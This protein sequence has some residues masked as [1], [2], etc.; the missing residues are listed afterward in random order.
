M[1]ERFKGM[2]KM[3]SMREKTFEEIANE[4]INLKERVDFYKYQC[5]QY[6]LLCD[7]WKMQ[8]DDLRDLIKEYQEYLKPKL[9]DCKHGSED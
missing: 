8:C 4:L 9:M 5:S 6:M 2:M 1:L 3:H 7:A